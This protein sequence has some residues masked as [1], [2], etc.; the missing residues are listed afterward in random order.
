MSERIDKA[1]EKM[2]W[3]TIIEVAKVLSDDATITQAETAAAVEP[4]KAICFL[5]RNGQVIF[6]LDGNLI[7]EWYKNTKKGR[8]SGLKRIRRKDTK[9]DVTTKKHPCSL[10]LFEITLCIPSHSHFCLEFSKRDDSSTLFKMGAKPKWTAQLPSIQPCPNC[11][12]PSL[13]PWRDKY[14]WRITTTKTVEG[15]LSEKRSRGAKE[16]D[17][18]TLRDEEEACQVVCRSLAGIRRR[19]EKGNLEIRRKKLLRK[20]IKNGSSRLRRSLVS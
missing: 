3:R 6:D 7:E 5:I 8:R 18:R 1:A 15:P 17:G 19:N 4:A 16:E 9:E 12:D 20:E 13:P 14:R 10:S 11:G 2:E